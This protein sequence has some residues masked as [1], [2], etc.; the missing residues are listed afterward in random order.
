MLTGD[1]QETAENIG[2]SCKLFSRRTHIFRLADNETF[3]LR[4]K[5]WAAQSLI[6]KGIRPLLG[7]GEE[8][9]H[10]GM[11]G[12]EFGSQDSHLEMTIESRTKIGDNNEG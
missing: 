11:E 3:K 7:D 1:K 12:T 9:Y 4:E 6:G 2:Y 5:L 10:P 8:W